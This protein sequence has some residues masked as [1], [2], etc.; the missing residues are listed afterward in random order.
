MLQNFPRS[1]AVFGMQTMLFAY[2]KGFWGNGQISHSLSGLSEAAESGPWL[3]P[4][5]NLPHSI[6]FLSLF[7]FLF[8]SLNST[9]FHELLLLLLYVH[10][11][12]HSRRATPK[13]R[14]FPPR[15]A[16]DNRAYRLASIQKATFPQLLLRV[17]QSYVLRVCIA[18]PRLDRVLNYSK[19]SATRFNKY[20]YRNSF[21]TIIIVVS[22]VRGT[23]KF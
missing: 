11:Y 22:H 16:A 13:R 7:S 12:I 23:C 6:F 19:P 15:A 18:S 3:L 5:F 21:I 1:T 20:L 2:L 4:S 9:Q 10:T 17:S 14:E 8:F